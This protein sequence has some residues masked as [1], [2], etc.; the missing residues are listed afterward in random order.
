LIQV[1][2][3]PYLLYPDPLIK[4]V[5]LMNKNLVVDRTVD[6]PIVGMLSSQ[7]LQYLY[8]YTKTEYSGIGAI[9]DLG[10]WLGSSTIA[11]ATGLVEN[12]KPQVKNRQIHA[13]DIFIWE[14]WMDACGGVDGRDLKTK[15]KPGDSF[16]EEYQ[17]QTAPWEKQICA[18][19]GDLLQLGWQG[20][21]IEFLFIDAM[22]SWELTNSIIYDFFPCL[23]PDR[24]IVVQQDFSHYYTYWIH[25]IMY[26][27]RDYFEVVRDIPHSGS[28]VFKYIKQ[29]PDEQLKQSYALESFS[30]DEID[31]AFSYSASLV[32][33]S[34]SSVILLA[35]MRA[36]TDSKTNPLADNIVETLSTLEMKMSDFEIKIS[37]F[38]LKISELQVPVVV[39]GGKRWHFRQAL[40]HLSQ[41]IH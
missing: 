39:T 27:F 32:T 29:I 36:L 23:V 15:F 35:K 9:V 2:P 24:S 37:G 21:E 28:V 17:R 8:E 40:K 41:I 25:L 30:A 5:K 13:Y 22:K 3:D 11:M 20:G 10:C 18:H 7:E 33:P 26:R 38:E 12:T 14:S 19:P 6:A 4:V 34:E 1:E 31:N 16:F